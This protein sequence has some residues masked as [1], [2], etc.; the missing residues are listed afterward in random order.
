MHRMFSGKE[1]GRGQDSGLK[2]QDE[3]L[4]PTAGVSSVKILNK[5]VLS[6][7]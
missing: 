3:V 4:S 1:Q 5:L 7:H 2:S 6:H